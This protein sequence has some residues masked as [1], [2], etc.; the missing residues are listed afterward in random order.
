MIYARPQ[1]DASLKLCVLV[2]IAAL[3]P[4]F[5]AAQSA[6]TAPAARR[7]SLPT[8]IVTFTFG[9]S[10]GDNRDVTDG[11]GDTELR[12]SD[13]D[14]GLAF[15]HRGRRVTFDLSGQSAVRGT[16]I[17]IRPM[18][19]QGAFDLAFAGARNQFHVA[20]MVSYAPSYQFGPVPEAAAPETEAASNHGDLSNARLAALVTSSGVDWTGNVGQQFAISASYNFR[21]TQFDDPSLDMTSHE[22]G[23]LVTRK[24]SRFVALHGGYASR[25]AFSDASADGMMRVHD[26][27]AGLDVSHPLNVSRRLSFNFGSGSALVPADGTLA[28]RLTAEAGLTRLIGRTWSARVGVKRAVRLVEGFAQ[29]LLDNAVDVRVAGTLGRHVSPFSTGSFSAGNVGAGT[30]ASNRYTT[31]TTASGVSFYIGRRAA[32]E[33]QHFISGNQFGD[34]VLLPPGVIAHRW[35]QGLRVGFTWRG[36]ILQRL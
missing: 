35:R 28:F 16:D 23:F 7:P 30:G 24:I 2:A 14:A 18:R 32:V 34:A 12:T 15:H 17:E 29:P 13:L 25:V 11:T 6:D 20:Q 27:D 26:I 5:A 3:V 21:R 31:W 9:L 8:K 4:A 33:V 22:A 1:Y 10:A 19:Q 36:P